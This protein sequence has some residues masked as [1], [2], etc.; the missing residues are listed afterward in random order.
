MSR[1]LTDLIKSKQVLVFDFDGVLVDSVEVKT[2]AF[3]ALYRPYGEDVVKQV[4]SHHRANGGVNRFEKFKYYHA[5]FLGKVIDNMEIQRLSD[6]FSAI[7][8]DCVI[9]A[10]TVPGAEEFLLSN[11]KDRVCYVNSGTPEHEMNII[12]SKRSW[13]MYFKRIY[14]SPT[15]K[16]ENLVKIMKA[17]PDVE[18]VSFLFFGD[19]LSDLYASE[20]CGVDFI[21]ITGYGS[22]VLVGKLSEDRLIRDFRDL[23]NLE[24]EN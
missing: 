19:A 7:V 20:E 5:N 4:I 10:P 9:N 23:D 17:H 24:K 8:V 11:Y 1:N 2:E 13:D 6:A 22:S 3:A 14:G 18:K 21:G 16:Q 12:V 15:S